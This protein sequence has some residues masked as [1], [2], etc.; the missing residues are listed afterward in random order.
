M[1]GSG[2]DTAAG[3]QELLL[4]PCETLQVRSRTSGLLRSTPEGGAL[5]QGRCAA[6]PG[7]HWLPP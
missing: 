7:L 1:W 4:G 6:A 5:L 2:G 3:G